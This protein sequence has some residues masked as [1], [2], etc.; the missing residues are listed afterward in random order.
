MSLDMLRD[1]C[2]KEEVVSVLEFQRVEADYPL[3]PY[4]MTGV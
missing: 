3:S 1:S 4:R 2:E